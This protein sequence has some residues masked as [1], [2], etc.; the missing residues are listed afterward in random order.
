MVQLNSDWTSRT[1]HSFWS[2]T[3]YKPMM[4]TFLHRDNFAGGCRYWFIRGSQW[5]TGLGVW[6]C[7]HLGSWHGVSY[8]GK[9]NP[10][11]QSL[12]L[13]S[14]SSVTSLPNACFLT[15]ALHLQANTYD[16]LPEQLLARLSHIKPSAAV[17]PDL[18][19][20]SWAGQI[21]LCRFFHSFPRRPKRS[22]FVQSLQHFA[23]RYSE[24]QTDCSSPQPQVPCTSPSYSF[25]FF[26]SFFINTLL[27]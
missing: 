8:T 7:Y 13:S 16:E 5:G 1:S 25:D 12:F 10:H 24:V 21:N 14:S 3:D 23:V 15:V 27:V 22:H 4:N 19:N 26:A 9:W 2:C 11:R 18:E 20:I 17:Y 6:C